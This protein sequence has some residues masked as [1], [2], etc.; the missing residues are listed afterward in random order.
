VC[1]D[2][3]C[4]YRLYLACLYYCLQLCFISNQTFKALVSGFVSGKFKNMKQPRESNPC[5]ALVSNSPT[6]SRTCVGDAAAER[7]RRS[8]ELVEFVELSFDDPAPAHDKI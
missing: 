6:L 2:N 5:A 1:I 4:I 7:V 8:E 3:T